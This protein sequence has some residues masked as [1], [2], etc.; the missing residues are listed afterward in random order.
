MRLRPR[1]SRARHC[2]GIILAVVA[3][4]VPAIAERMLRIGIEQPCASMPSGSS[5]MDAQERGTLVLFSSTRTS[6]FREGR[7]ESGYVKG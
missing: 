2:V 7:R 6:A 5:R 3:A 4:L 1:W